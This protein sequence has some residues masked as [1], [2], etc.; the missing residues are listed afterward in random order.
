[1]VEVFTL[2]VLY[3]LT[4]CVAT[5]RTITHIPK[6]A[7]DNLYKP[8]G[9][10][11]NRSTQIWP[12]M[13]PCPAGKIIGNA[14]KMIDVRTARQTSGLATLRLRIQATPATTYAAITRITQ[15]LKELKMN[16]LRNSDTCLSLPDKKEP[17]NHSLRLM[18][19]SGMGNRFSVEV[20]D[21]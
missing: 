11:N 10:N 17:F 12:N 16:S 14:Q 19:G 21:S 2:N 7:K 5:I 3:A 20:W 6:I 15:F 18:P 9:K 8:A 1:M 13:M 4:L